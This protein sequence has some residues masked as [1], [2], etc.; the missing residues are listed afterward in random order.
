M[1]ALSTWIE[2]SSFCL[3]TSFQTNQVASMLTSPNVLKQNAFLGFRVLRPRRCHNMSPHPREKRR[4]RSSECL[5]LARRTRSKQPKMAKPKKETLW[6]P[7]HPKKPRPSGVTTHEDLCY[8]REWLLVFTD[9]L[10]TKH[11]SSLH[12]CILLNRNALE[13]LIDWMFLE[14]KR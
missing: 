4:R 14:S 7:S 10:Y 1:K 2:L 8:R 5:H 13:V 3:S 9:H 12:V 11:Y 6:E